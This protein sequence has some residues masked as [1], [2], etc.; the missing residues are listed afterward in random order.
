MLNQQDFL[1]IVKFHNL[2]PEIELKDFLQSQ[3]LIETN[4]SKGEIKVLSFQ[5]DELDLSF[6]KAGLKSEIISQYLT[7]IDIGIAPEEQQNKFYR[8]PISNKYKTSAISL[9]SIQQ[10]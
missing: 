5:G 4:L 6:K 9:K 10:N 3:G 8:I 2:M 1:A 7:L